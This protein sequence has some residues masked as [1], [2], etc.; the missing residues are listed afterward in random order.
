VPWLRSTQ[1]AP[2]GRHRALG[3]RTLDVV[4][5]DAKGFGAAA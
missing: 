2:L 1:F 3:R 5:F 4:Y